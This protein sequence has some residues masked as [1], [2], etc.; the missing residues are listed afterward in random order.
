M[1]TQVGPLSRWWWR[2]SKKTRIALSV[3]S[4]ILGIVILAIPFSPWI[5]FHTFKPSPVYPYPTKLSG[6]S[7]LP[8]IPDKQKEP[9]SQQ[10]P[11]GNRLVIPKIGV[12][13]EIVEGKD[14]RALYRGIWHYPTSSI[15]ERGGNTVLTGHRFQYLAGPRTL[16]LLDQMHV[17]D[18]IIVYWKGTEYD[19]TVRQRKIVNPTAVEVLDNTPNAQLTIFTC[20]PLFSTKQRLVLIADPINT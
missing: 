1:R 16:Y 13:V 4:I 14:E 20:T 6:T 11:K 2:I 9:S 7:Y 8:A 15:P 18:V 10:L 3:T 5:L 19:Y 17:G 12:D